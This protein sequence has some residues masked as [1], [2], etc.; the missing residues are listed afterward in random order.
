MSTS[1]LE[2]YVSDS[3]ALMISM[4]VHKDLL[5]YSISIIIIVF[6]VYPM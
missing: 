6:I 4:N 3:S 5:V 1:F 2:T